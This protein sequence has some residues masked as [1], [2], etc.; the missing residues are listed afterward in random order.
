MYATS[1]Y[2]NAF[3]W[4]FIS[5]NGIFENAIKSFYQIPSF[6][7]SLSSSIQIA[8]MFVLNI[9][10]SILVIE[11]GVRRIT[12]SGA[13]IASMGSILATVIR[14]HWSYCLFYGFVVGIAE[15]FMFVPVTFL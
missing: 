4:G 15:T 5:S 6:K 10:I 3:T 14:Y 11:Y 1:F 2:V 13:C 9:F 7:S 12:I 8:T